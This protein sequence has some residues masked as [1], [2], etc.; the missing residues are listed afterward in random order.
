M[1]NV[2]IMLRE[3]IIGVC[4]LE[5]VRR[6]NAIYSGSFEKADGTADQ[7]RICEAVG[8]MFP[9]DKAASIM[10]LTTKK[11][12]ALQPQGEQPP[13]P[14]APKAAASEVRRAEAAFAEYF[15]E[16]PDQVRDLVEEARRLRAAMGKAVSD[17]EAPPATRPSGG[18]AAGKPP[19]GGV[20]GPGA[21]AAVRTYRAR[22]TAQP[23]SALDGEIAKFAC[24]RAAYSSIDMMDFVRYLK[25]KGFSFEEHIVL[26]KIY[27]IIEERK[28]ESVFA[29]EKEVEGLIY[30]TPAPTEPDISGFLRHLR[31]AGL[32]F[33]EGDVRR[34]IDIAARRKHAKTF[35]DHSS[36]GG[37]QRVMQ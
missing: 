29:I 19:S 11:L 16:N 9:T 22:V 12:M 28:K 32:V 33:E 25:D 20:A 14:E 8:Y 2:D 37:A 26:G 10:A 5:G 30:A 6:F 23:S 36:G 1:G 24:G 15:N 34:M 13:A 18:A 27:E 3:S 7:Q 17:H 35:T 31:D 4:G 21:P